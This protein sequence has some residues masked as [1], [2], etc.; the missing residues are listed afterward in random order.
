MSFYLGIDIGGTKVQAVILNGLKSQKVRAFVMPTLRSKKEFLASLEKFFRDIS[1]GKRIA[2]IG[3]G[4]P[5]MVNLKKGILLRAPNL[6]FLDNWEVKKFFQ[7]FVGRVVVDND[8]RCFLRAEWL[9]GA[10]K[11][12]KNVA[13]LAV[14][15]GIGG[16]LVVDGKMYYGAHGSAGE[17]GHMIVNGDRTLE[18]LGAKAAAEQMIDTTHTVSIGVANLINAFDPEIVVL[19]GG[20]VTQGGIDI[21]KV[22][23]IA[24]LF[25]MSPEAK[26]TPIVAGK[27]GEAAQAIG[28]AL[29]LG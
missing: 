28:A 25:I 26:S 2:G 24:K 10:A 3:V 7:K 16:G 19:G 29:F 13:G 6:S 21:V 22:R 11:G 1:S 27:L 15:T 8:S 18:Q 23:T 4:V 20:G 17:F 12:C 9:W 5:G 14:G